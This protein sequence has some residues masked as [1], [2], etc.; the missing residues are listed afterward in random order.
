MNWGVGRFFS[1]AN[2]IN[3]ETIDPE[4]PDEELA[5]P[6]AVKAQLPLST[7]NL[8]GYLLLDDIETGDDIGLAGRYEFL[9]EGY[10]LTVG[11]LY[12]SNR[13]WAVMS[14]ATGA[15]GDVTVFGELVLEGDSDKVFIVENGNSSLGTA[16]SDS[17]FVSGTVGAVQHHN[18][19]RPLRRDGQRSILF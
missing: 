6:V 18:R 16:T 12:R 14:T 10:E 4:N 7:D 1:P 17:L 5:G 3:L 8:T 19:R 15:V 2:L 9:V 11:G 13:P